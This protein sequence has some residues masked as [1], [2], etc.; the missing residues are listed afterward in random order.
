VSAQT[1]V[2]SALRKLEQ[3]A[4]T[5]GWRSLL[6][7]FQAL[8][9][10]VDGDPPSAVEE[11]IETYSV[12][13]DKVF[14]PAEP[15]R[16]LAPGAQWEAGIAFAAGKFELYNAMIAL[17]LEFSH[18][19]PVNLTGMGDEVVER[20]G[21]FFVRYDCGSHFSIWRED[22]ITAAQARQATLGP[23]HLNNMVLSLHNDLTAKGIN[24]S[25]SNYMPDFN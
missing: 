8:R 12:M 4:A 15:V 20:D 5:L 3:A 2:L 18:H 25:V 9:R 13:L 22:E 10:L 24:S 14:V 19:V 21:R 7:R 6:P 11:L 16:L 1:R 23:M 17:W